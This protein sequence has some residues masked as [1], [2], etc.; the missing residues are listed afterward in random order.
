MDKELSLLPG[1][2]QSY[3]ELIHHCRNV[4]KARVSEIVAVNLPF[5]D[6]SEGRVLMEEQLYGLVLQMLSYV[7]ANSQKTRKDRQ[8]EGIRAARERGVHIGR[9]P[10]YNACDYIDIFKKVDSGEMDR[11]SARKEIGVCETTYF[12]L[13]RELREKGLLQ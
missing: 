10:K 13:K 4:M 2:P 6:S 12:K 7:Q 1:Q 8:R 3:D 11:E 5:L 9:R